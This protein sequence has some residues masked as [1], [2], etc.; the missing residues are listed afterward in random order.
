MWNQSVV[1]LIFLSF[2]LGTCEFIMIGILPDLSEDLSVSLPQ[3]GMLISYLAMA[4]ALGTPLISVFASRFI[5]YRFYDMD[6][7]SLYCSKRYNHMDQQLHA[8]ADTPCF[9]GCHLRRADFRIHDICS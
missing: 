8:P 2:M 9:S 5:R 7:S 6:D 3:A 4:Y 1:C